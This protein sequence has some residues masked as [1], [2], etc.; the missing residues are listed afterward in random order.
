MS[1]ANDQKAYRQRM[2]DD[3]YTLV[4]GIYAPANLKLRRKIRVAAAELVKEYNDDNLDL[5]EDGDDWNI[6]EEEV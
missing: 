6:N 3:G 1:N 2:Q 5:F 4:Q